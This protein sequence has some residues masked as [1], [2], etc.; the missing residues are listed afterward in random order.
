MLRLPISIPVVGSI[1]SIKELMGAEYEVLKRDT[2]AVTVQGFDGSSHT[3]W[4]SKDQVTEYQLDSIMFVG[5]IVTVQVNQNVE[6]ET[7]YELDGDKVPHDATFESFV[8]M[9]H[10]MPVN[11]VLAGI[12]EFLIKDITAQREE[13]ATSAKR[14]T[15]KFHAAHGVL[16]DDA[17]AAHIDGLLEKRKATTN[18]VIKANIDARLKELGYSDVDVEALKLEYATATAARKA[19]I[20]KE[21]ERVGETIEG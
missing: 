2:Y 19:K 1:A 11:M 15:P 17:K 10:L 4:V 7:Y 6:G 18:P 12:P 9:S 21:L 20:V 16:G 14:A 5:N 13:A 8:G 3:V